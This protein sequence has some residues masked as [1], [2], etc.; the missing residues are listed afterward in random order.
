M[1]NF[2][3]QI[4]IFP[5]GWAPVDWTLCEGQ[6][7]RIND[8]QALFSLIGTKFGGDGQST[9]ALPNLKVEAEALG[10]NLT[11]AIALAGIFPSRM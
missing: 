7:L 8:Y 1:D 9:F 10:G 6:I 5:Y 2:L 3:G 11:Y 4:A